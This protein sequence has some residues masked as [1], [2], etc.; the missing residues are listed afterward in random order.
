MSAVF[1]CLYQYSP[2]KYKEG[3]YVEKIPKDPLGNPY[4]YTNPGIPGEFDPMSF[5]S[6]MKKGWEVN[7]A[8]IENWKM[9]KE[10]HPLRWALKH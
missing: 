5:G 6:N 7:N 9:S 4:I 1:F 2:V 10:P 3:G 8:H